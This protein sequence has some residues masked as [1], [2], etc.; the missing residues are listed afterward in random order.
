M[1]GRHHSSRDHCQPDCPAY[2]PPVPRL[3]EVIG[4][5]FEKPEA[6]DEMLNM[7]ENPT[8]PHYDIADDRPLV[9]WDSLFPDQSG[10]L[11]INKAG[12]VEDALEWVFPEDQEWVKGTDSKD[13]RYSRKGSHQILWSMW[14]EKN[15]VSDM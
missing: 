12:Q 15:Q 13:G 14:H 2:P 5:G 4:Q 11:R 7:K 1:Q 6:V 9:L 3:A 10:E 8:R